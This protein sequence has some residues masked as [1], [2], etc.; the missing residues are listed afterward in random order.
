[1]SVLACVVNVSEGR[2]ADVVSAIA[3]AAGTD[4]LDVHSDPH[5]HRSVLWLVG[6]DAP[7]AV[8]AEAVARIDL[9]RHT[10]AHPRLGA[11]DVVPFVPLAHGSTGEALAAR[12]RFVAWAGAELALPAFTYGT[13]RSLPEVRR[14]A[15]R[16]LRPDAGPL[17]PHPTA[18]AVAVGARPALVAYNLWLDADH[19]T[20]RAVAAAVRGPAVR[21][22]GLRLGDDVQV[23]L[24]LVDPLRFG[25]ADAYD[26]VAAL[27]PVARAELVGLAPAAVVDAVPPDRWHQLDISPDRTVEAKLAARSGGTGRPAPAPP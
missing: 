19:S 11:V 4:L 15:F 25:P 22:L 3:A 16:R 17:R 12:D 23:S 8:A 26:A 14:G 10:G 7:R 1:M 21:A 2:R 6:E 13:D 24:N 20:A 9:R 18:G 5:H 27:A